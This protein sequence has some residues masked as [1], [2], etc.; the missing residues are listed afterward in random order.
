MTEEYQLRVT[1]QVASSEQDLKAWLSHEKGLDVRTINHVRV[2]KRSIDARQR[3]I[4]VNLEVR[5]YINGT[6]Q[7]DEY[8]HTE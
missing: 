1:P 2:L 7:D 6:P 8:Q 4:F 5:V 3:A